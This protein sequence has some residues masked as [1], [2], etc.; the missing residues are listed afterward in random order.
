MNMSAND[1]LKGRKTLKI[2]NFLDEFEMDDIKRKVD[3]VGLFQSF[4]VKL[5]KKGRS[6]MGLCPW[7][8]DTNPSLSVDRDQGL[9]NCFGCGERGDIFT[10]TRKMRGIEFKEALAYLKTLISVSSGTRL[11]EKASAK[12][13]DDNAGRGDGVVIGDGVG[14]HNVD[15]AHNDNIVGGVD[16]DGDFIDTDAA[17]DDLAGEGRDDIAHNVNIAGNENGVDSAADDIASADDSA[18]YAAA[19]KQAPSLRQGSAQ[20]AVSHENAE[21]VLNAPTQSN[22]PTKLT[23]PTQLNAPTHSNAPAKSIALT[24]STATGV[25]FTAIAE[26]YHKRLYAND[27]ALSYLHKRGLENIQ[28]Y[29]RF[30]IGYADG[31]LLEKIGENQRNALIE[32]GI[33][34]SAGREHFRGCVIFP[35]YDDSGVVVGMYGR[36]IEPPPGIPLKNGEGIKHGLHP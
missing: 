26:Y 4:G 25:T 18:D 15:N 29:E 19:E 6:Y 20:T 11:A 35:I 16:A 12:G 23:A 36:A 32:L 13:D 31:S 7:H 34:N 27:K 22:M 14:A 24:Q 5:T 10:L 33:I 30:M 28:N 17:A 3:I 2:A 8:N 1:R 9:Y 21:G